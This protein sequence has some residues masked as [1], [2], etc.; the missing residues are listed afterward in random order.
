MT[1]ESVSI[2]ISDKVS[3]SVATKLLKIA[4][5]A[6]EGYSAIERLQKQIAMLNSGNLSSLVNSVNSTNSAMQKLTATSKSYEIENLKIAAS[7][8]KLQQQIQKT[9]KALAD[10]E[11]AINRSI[12]SEM[13]ASA[14]ADRASIANLR[15]AQA[16]EKAAKAT[17]Q[18]EREAENLKR[19]ISPLYAIE[20]S[21][22]ESVKRASFLYEQ[23]AID[24]QTYTSAIDHYENKLK[25]AKMAQDLFNNNLNK[26][27]RTAQISRHHMMNLGFQL[28][29]IGV[30]LASG[31]NPLVVLVQQGAQ[32]QG[33]ASQAEVSL[34]R[35]GLAAVKMM[36]RFI[37]IVATIGAMVASLKLFQSEASEN[38][39]LEE[40]AKS[41]GAT[42]EQIRKLK[43]DTVTFG[44]TLKGFWKT[45][46]QRTGAGSF[47]SAIY[48]SAKKAFKNTL[49]I[50]VLAAQ[51]IV[52]LVQSI[53][54]VFAELWARIPTPAKTAFAQVGN[55]IISFFETVA[56]T[57]IDAINLIIEALNKITA[58]KI[59]PFSNVTFDRLPIEFAAASGKDLSQVFLESYT[60]NLEGNKASFSKF[61][62]DFVK[63]SQDA[64]KA[65]IE[66]TLTE[67]TQDS[68]ETSLAK[69]NLQLDNEIS[70][71][72]TLQP[73]REAQQKLDQIEEQLI[74]KRIK[75]TDEERNGLMSKIKAIQDGAEVQRQMDAIYS[76]SVK[77][78]TEYNAAIKASDQLLKMGAISQEAHA[79]S[80]LRAYEAY[81]NIRDPL[82]QL[83][84]ELEQE[85][86]LLQLLPAQ[87]EIESQIMQ[88]QN[89]MI[90]KGIVLKQTEIDQLREKLT[91]L[92]QTNALAQ[93]EQNLLSNGPGSRQQFQT[94]VQAIGNLRNS[95]GSGFTQG[96]Q[97]TAVE[98]MVSGMGVDTSSFSVGIEAQLEQQ[99][100]YFE[101]LKQ[102]RDNDLISEQEYNSARMQLWVKA[103]ETQLAGTQ[104]FFT[105]LSQL[106]QSQSKRIA[107]I[108]KAA[109][110][111]KAIID[112]YTA[113]TG[114]YASL[115]SIPY[116]GPV[117]GAA[118]AGAA[119]V[120]GMANVRAIKSQQP[121]FQQGGYTGDMAID[122]IAG[123][124]HGQEYVMDAAT[125]SAV[126][127]ENLNALRNGSASIQRADS[128]STAAAN[129]T[130]TY[131]N[132]G[133]SKTAEFKQI[134]PYEFKIIARDEAAKVV[135]NMTPELVATQIRDP[136]SKVSKALATSTKTERQR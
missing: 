67:E 49:G 4:E 30:S 47:F 16:R 33:I 96:D 100:V 21:H 13:R 37:P 50:I 31:Q 79:Q 26:I 97:A 86:N 58:V 74:G 102:L 91:I 57:S 28:Q 109:A 38:A 136:N 48:E 43:L 120:A 9:Q 116:V 82:R 39:G 80:T 124:V 93:E 119:I 133:T 115:A 51:S 44:D 7:Q 75:L 118:A 134:S 32:I 65:R 60:Q 123:V 98:S 15:L 94:Q 20:Q 77:P 85:Y 1:D 87:R 10:T 107:A 54:D 111:S 95:P 5:A 41:L 73:L 22:A 70:R 63:N 8:Q 72:G 99:K 71:L 121:G 69:V 17:N 68:R 126:G 29:D 135:E 83:N 90:Q 103:Q 64:A 104:T 18:L 117:L 130:F 76:D 84:S 101:Q 36:S 122:K 46:D 25:Q 24:L 89:Q 23:G 61:L 113:A 81:A 35:L 127:V 53:S 132:Y 105:Q 92:Q 88:I 114:A 6:R 62:A 78:L 56:N 42:G 19:S 128:V 131:E 27:G 112:T 110:I 14:A 12:A 34:G 55:T 59:D 52:A 2:E 125:T 45:I 66:K 108:G 106:Q 40:F 11:T 129:F 3:P